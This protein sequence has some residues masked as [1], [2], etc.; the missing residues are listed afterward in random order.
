MQTAPI[1]LVLLPG[2]DGTGEL[3]APFVQALQANLQAKNI[4]IIVVSY[5]SNQVLSYAQLTELASAYIP[6]DEEYILLGESFSGPIAIMLAARA[7]NQ[8][9]GLI[10][11]CTFARNPRPQLSKLSFMLPAMPI[12]NMI[13]QLAKRF[14]MANFNNE[15]IAKI[16]FATIQK[17]SPN[18]MRARLDAIIG[19]DY[20]ESLQKI[21]VP[22]LYL[23]G[24]SDCLVPPSAGRYITEQ[25]K[26]VELKEMHA[27]HLLLQI[28]PNEATEIVHAFIAKTLNKSALKN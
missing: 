28:V 14:L 22:I 25:A 23:Q 15:N 2:M 13:M 4:K 12:N 7:D 1:N 21:K 20:T 9:K 5:P 27:P 8:L 3:F 17:V 10:L 19:A 18:V 6:Q 11:S 24:K 26:N 16:L